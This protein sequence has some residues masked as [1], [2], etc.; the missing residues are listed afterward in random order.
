[1]CLLEGSRPCRKASA[2]SADPTLGLYHLTLKGKC[3]WRETLQCM[4]KEEKGKYE[5]GRV[6][7]RELPTTDNLKVDNLTG[8]DTLL[9]LGSLVSFLVLLRV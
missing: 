7:E 1:M 2:F 5:S 9:F 6:R 8:Q 3:H 4:E